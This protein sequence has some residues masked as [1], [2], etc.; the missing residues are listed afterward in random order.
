[1]TELE[2]LADD[3]GSGALRWALSAGAVAGGAL[4]TAGARRYA[5]ARSAA[6]PDPMRREPFGELHTEPIIVTANDGVELVV[7]VEESLHPPQGAPAD[8][9]TIVFIPGFCLPMDCW[10]FQRRD[11]RDLGRLVFYDQ[12]AHGRSGRGTPASATIEQLAD[13]LHTVLAEVAPSGPVV[14]IGHSLGGMVV[15][16]YADAHPTL[17]G[18]RIVGVALLTTSPGRLAE[19][20]LGIPAALMQRIWPMAPTVV[21][22]VATNP[23][24][25]RRGMKA[26]RGIGLMITRR[27][28]FGRADVPTSLARFAGRLLS[29]TPL[30][31]FAEFFHEFDRHDK[32]AALPVLQRCPTLIVAAER[33]MLTPAAHSRAMAAVLPKAELLV[34][35]KSGHL[36]Q[37]EDPDEVNAAL[38]RLLDRVKLAAGA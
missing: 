11:L 33:D 38:R 36:V 29:S 5:R 23:L 15:M 6:R 10:H 4:A 13:D 17:F 32:E 14:L 20:S 21:N 30:D 28:S 25:V 35:P 9:P 7:E 8:A 16:G 1:M 34:L 12:R 2:L 22:R 18:D 27:L 3:S 31:V 19:M 24:A 37:L 26:D